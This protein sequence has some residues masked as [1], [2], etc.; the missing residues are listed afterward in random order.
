MEGLRLIQSEQQVDPRRRNNFSLGL[1]AEISI[2]LVNSREGT[3]RRH[4]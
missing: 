1:H 3:R 2:R 4:F